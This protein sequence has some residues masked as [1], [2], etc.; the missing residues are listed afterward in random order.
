[1]FKDF[2]E[3]PED[4]KTHIRYPQ[5]LFYIQIVQYNTY[6]MQD[7]KVFYNKEDLW[8]IPKENYGGE[9]INVEPYYIQMRLPGEDHLEFILMIPLTPNNKDNMIAWLAARCDGEHYGEL[10]VYK[11]P[12]EKLIYGSVADRSAD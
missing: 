12:K 7:P 5:D 8:T 1:M 6:H 9:T 3:M 4:L 10:L 2:S 11:F